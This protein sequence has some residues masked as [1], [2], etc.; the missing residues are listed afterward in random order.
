MSKELKT[1]KRGEL[2]DERES[3][4]VEKK[5]L[6]LQGSQ[7]VSIRRLVEGPKAHSDEEPRRVPVLP[8]GREAF[9]QVREGEEGEEEMA[10]RGHLRWGSPS[11]ELLRLIF[12]PF[13]HTCF[14]GGSTLVGTVSRVRKS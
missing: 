3:K 2:G 10:V 12:S 13:Y 9:E 8:W 5:P 11:S 6:P 7:K 14:F 1:R 4:R